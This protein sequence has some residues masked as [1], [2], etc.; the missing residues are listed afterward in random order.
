MV[1]TGATRARVCT[2]HV[3]HLSDLQ[4]NGNPGPQRL[5]YIG[6]LVKSIVPLLAA[7]LLT[8]A[9]NTTGIAKNGG[10]GIYAIVDKVA[11]EPDRASPERVRI[12]G[13]FVV[14]IRMSSGDYAPPKRGFLYFKTVHGRENAARRDWAALTSVAGTGEVI[15]FA[16]YWVP[17]PH[18]GGNPHHTLEVTVHSSV[19]AASPDDYPLSFAEV[20]SG[21]NGI[22]KAGHPAFDSII[23]KQLKGVAAGRD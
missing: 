15:G 17:D 1:R 4:L 9:M 22:V 7:G 5:G 23:L 2:V 11:F 10:V 8:A 13:T 3:P 12:D 20:L 14:P 18:T 19:G 16:Y 21:E 6:G